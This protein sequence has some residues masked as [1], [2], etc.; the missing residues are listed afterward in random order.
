[1]KKT[2]ILIISVILLLGAAG[3]FGYL[4]YKNNE[5][6]KDTDKYSE[7][8]KKVEKAIKDDKEELTEKEDEY[9]K[10]KEKVKDSLEELEVWENMEKELN[11]A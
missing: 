4:F 6:K 2:I 10:L 5:I 1:M 7:N 9:E 11:N 3:L 8:I